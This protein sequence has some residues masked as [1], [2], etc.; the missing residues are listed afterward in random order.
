ME[1]SEDLKIILWLLCRKWIWE[2]QETE[3]EDEFG[4]YFSGS[5]ER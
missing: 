1:L 2:E 4:G 5:G 3:W